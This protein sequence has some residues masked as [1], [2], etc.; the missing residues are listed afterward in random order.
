MN[1]QEVRIGTVFEIQ[2]ATNE[3]IADIKCGGKNIL[4][5][6]F[7]TDKGIGYF[8][9][10]EYESHIDE[11]VIMQKTFEPKWTMI[12]LKMLLKELNWDMSIKD[13]HDF[14]IKSLIYPCLGILLNPSDEYDWS[15]SK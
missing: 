13:P 3:L 7:H 10:C 5:L 6:Q 4:L 2:Q 8:Y 1:V 12:N 14:P 15:T 9:P 11:P